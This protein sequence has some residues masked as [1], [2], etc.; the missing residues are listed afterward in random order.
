MLRL[1]KKPK[2]INPRV[3][4]WEQEKHLTKTQKDKKFSFVTG[5]VG[6]RQGKDNGTGRKMEGWGTAQCEGLIEGLK[7]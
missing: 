6:G 7:M 3:I 4:R 5:R 2:K 1:K